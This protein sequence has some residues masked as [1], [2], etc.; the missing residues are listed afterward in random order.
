MTTT[1]EDRVTAR[2]RELIQQMADRRLVQW[3]R[4]GL[5]ESTLLNARRDGRVSV[6][7][8]ARI[9]HALGFELVL[10]VRERP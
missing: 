4:V 6:R 2:V 9:C 7:T 1:C 5:P 3:S 8:L 10:N